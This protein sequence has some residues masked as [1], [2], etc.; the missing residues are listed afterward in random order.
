[1]LCFMKNK[2]RQNKHL[3][4]LCIIQVL[5]LLLKCFELHVKFLPSGIYRQSSSLF[6]RGKM[7]S[8]FLYKLINLSRE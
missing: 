7:V 2:K 8:L 3:E 6:G 4:A 1:M 5:L